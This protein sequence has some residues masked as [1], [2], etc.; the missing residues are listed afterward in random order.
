MTVAYLQKSSNPGKKYMVTII[1][2]DG[3]RKKV[4]FG[5]A[6]A[7]DYTK[8]K[9]KDRMK[10]YD[11]RHRSGENWGKAGIDK[12]GFW[13]KNILWSQP[14]LDKAIRSTSSKYH[15]TI[16]R[17]APPSASPKRS[18]KRSRKRS[19]KKSRSRSKRR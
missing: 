19:L 18:P 5:Q 6:G 7:S 3:R 8:H 15:I 4:H 10:R 12:A 17:G 11:D 2:N 13:S 14:S 16:K 1:H 9:D